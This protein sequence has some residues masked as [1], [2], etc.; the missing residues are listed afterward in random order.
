MLRATFFASFILLIG[1]ILDSCENHD[2]TE[3]V[4]CEAGLTLKDDIYPIVLQRCAVDECHNGSTDLPNWSDSTLFKENVF[5]VRTKVS[6]HEM[7]LNN[8]TGMTEEERHKVVCWAD[9]FIN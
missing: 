3:P 1:I 4:P 7:P 2:L 9:E 8:K 5:K 6:S